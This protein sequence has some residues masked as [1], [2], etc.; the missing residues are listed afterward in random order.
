MVQLAD[1]HQLIDPMGFGICLWEMVSVYVNTCTCTS[2]H[3]VL[4]W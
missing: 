3:D 4:L 1:G 2:V